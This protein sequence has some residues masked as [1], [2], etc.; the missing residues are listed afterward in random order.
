[1]SRD[2]FF[3]IGGGPIGHFYGVPV[4]DFMEGVGFWEVL[5][6]ELEKYLAN[7]GF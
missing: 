5:I 1:M 2:Q 6:Q 4:D 7:A 3:E